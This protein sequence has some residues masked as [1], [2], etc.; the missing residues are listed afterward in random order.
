MKLETISA[1][2]LINKDNHEIKHREELL[3]LYPDLEFIQ[4]IDNKLMTTSKTVNP[5]VDNFEF[6]F[7]INNS[8]ITIID[9][10]ASKSVNIKCNIC[11]D[12]DYVYGYPGRI[13]IMVVNKTNSDSYE[14]FETKY[15]NL[16]KEYNINDICIPK[17]KIYILDHIEKLKRG[18]TK[19]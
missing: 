5:A 10:Y 19:S 8:F 2:N 18:K 16:I 6:D 11:T 14:L 12:T 15:E 4:Y 7:R 1:I 17:I 9:L 13:P 3:K